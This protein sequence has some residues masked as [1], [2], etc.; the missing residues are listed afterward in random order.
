MAMQRQP[1]KRERAQWTDLRFAS[2]Y[3][4]HA[5]PYSQVAKDDQRLIAAALA[6]DFVDFTLPNPKWK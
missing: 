6:A 2:P 1:P 5:L 4:P 3:L